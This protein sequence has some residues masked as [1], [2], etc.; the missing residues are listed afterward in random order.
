MAEN[1]DLFMPIDSPISLQNERLDFELIEVEH[2]L[3]IQ[4]L[5]REFDF[6]PAE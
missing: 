1:P 5:I 2:A 3:E 6:Q 4:Q